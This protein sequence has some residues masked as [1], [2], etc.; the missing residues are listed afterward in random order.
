MDDP[1][2]DDLPQ[3]LRAVRLLRRMTQEEA[4]DAMGVSL[5][6]YTRWERGRMEPRGLNLRA[7]RRWLYGQGAA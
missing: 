6:A 1:T 4:A 2:I 3:V 5:R 7:V